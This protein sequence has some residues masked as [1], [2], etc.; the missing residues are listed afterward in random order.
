MNHL[1]SI[2]IHT[3]GS[4]QNFPF[5]LPFVRNWKT[6]EFPSPVTIFVGENDSGKSTLMETIACAVGSVTVGSQSVKTDPTLKD[7]RQLAK[8]M[9]LV[10]SKRSHRGFFLRAED[11]FGYVKQL[12][13]TR[14]E[15]ESD[16]NEAW[17]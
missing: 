16:L 13:K 10:W 12:S 7:I 9:K 8:A 15:L 6:L 11:F 2:E 1:R 4:Q 17:S 5:S 3:I 14:A